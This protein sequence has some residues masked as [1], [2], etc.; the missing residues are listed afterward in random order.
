[1]IAHAETEPTVEIIDGYRVDSETGEVLGLA[2]P[3]PAF[4][5][6]DE[7]SLNWVLGRFLK[8]EAEIA[9][10]D[11]SEVVIHARAV[12][13]NAEAMKRKATKRLDYLHNRFDLEI[14]EYARRALAGAK[15]R[16]LDTILGSVSL[17]TVKGGLRVKDPEAALN[18]AKTYCPHAVK[19]T[20]A[21]QIS[22]LTQEERDYLAA[23]VAEVS[24]AF[25]VKPDTETVKI[26]TG[27]AS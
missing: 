23:N 17:R 4:V 27:V 9:A 21:F 26:T 3:R 12:L 10:I 13:A 25:E 22:Q 5:V 16:T 14:L 2:E 15:R 18:I 6:D 19:K 20:E 24:H 11:N 1:M 7:D 8:V